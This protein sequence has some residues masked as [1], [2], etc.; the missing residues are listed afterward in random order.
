MRARRARELGVPPA[1]ILPVIGANTTH[2]EAVRVGAALRA[3]GARSILLV[4]DP[5]HLVRARAAFAREGFDV[6]PAPVDDPRLHGLGTAR[7]P[8]PGAR[9][10][11]RSSG[12]STTAW[13]DTL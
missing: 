2:E 10:F 9:S 13:R 3:R 7:A 12:G 8:G 4:S 5:L 11:A 1:V 6:R